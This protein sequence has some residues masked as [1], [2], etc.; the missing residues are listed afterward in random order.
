MTENVQTLR[1]SCPHKTPLCGLE[2]SCEHLVLP[3]LF[4]TESLSKPCSQGM[5]TE[6]VSPTP[7]PQHRHPMGGQ[8]SPWVSWGRS[9]LTPPPPWVCFVPQAGLQ[10]VLHGAPGAHVGRAQP[11]GAAAAALPGRACPVS[12]SPAQ[13]PHS[14]QTHPGGAQGHGGAFT[15]LRCL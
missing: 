6:K 8:S 13:P 2:K 5:A 3:N 10:R 14:L 11:E 7:V 1:N 15:L 9:L 4:G 12:P